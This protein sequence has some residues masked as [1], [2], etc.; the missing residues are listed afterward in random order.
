[1]DSLL[2]KL[3]RPAFDQSWPSRQGQFNLWYASQASFDEA[4]HCW[5]APTLCISCSSPSDHVLES[6]LWP[7]CTLHSACRWQ[8]NM[9]SLHQVVHIQNA[10]V[11][12][13]CGA[14]Q[15]ASWWLLMGSCI[16]AT[17]KLLIIHSCLRMKYPTDQSELALGNHMTLSQNGI[18]L[19]IILKI[20]YHLI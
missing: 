1:M 10:S 6:C 7:S 16:V 20:R 19:F 4:S 13:S 14:V 8:S 15:E 9:F 3:C 11:Q 12:T 5:H 18:N 2:C 17:V